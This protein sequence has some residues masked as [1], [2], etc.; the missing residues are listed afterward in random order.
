MTQNDKLI[1]LIS[2]LDA[3]QFTGLARILK[4]KL[5]EEKNPDGETAADRYQARD[6]MDVLD[7][8]LKDFSL[9]TRARRREILQLLNAAIKAGDSDADNS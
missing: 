2:K 6:F 7:D 9:S 8:V 4:V 3:V 5:V 1:K